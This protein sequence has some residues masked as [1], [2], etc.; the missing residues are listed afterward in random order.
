MNFVISKANA[1]VE[2]RVINQL[3]DE[4][5]SSCNN[6]VSFTS[7]RS[8]KYL[9]ALKYALMVIG[10][11]S[12]GL[13]EAPSFGIPTINIGD[14]QKGRL[15]ASSVINC[16]ATQESIRKALALASS[17]E[18]LEKASKTANPYGDGNT[19]DKII[20]VVKDCVLCDKIDIKKKFYNCE[21]K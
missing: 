9:S 1:D 6:I 8:F 18:F 3:I 17:K 13:V 16:N 19:S 12:S 11:S 5:A 10:N 20:A 15:Q 4:Y 21:A 7:L 2:G 14:R